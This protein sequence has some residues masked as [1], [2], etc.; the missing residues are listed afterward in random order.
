MRGVRLLGKSLGCKKLW[1]KFGIDC[2]R[3]VLQSERMYANPVLDATLAGD[4]R[5]RDRFH[6]Q[7]NNQNCGRTILR[8]VVMCG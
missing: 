8:T 1:M 7:A 6:E 2:D 3:A 4:T 5:C